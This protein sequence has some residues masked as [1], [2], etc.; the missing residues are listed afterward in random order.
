[1]FFVMFFRIWKFL[2][3]IWNSCSF[4]KGKIDEFITGMLYVLLINV[5]FVL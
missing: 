4:S 1:M 3:H 2:F 5:F